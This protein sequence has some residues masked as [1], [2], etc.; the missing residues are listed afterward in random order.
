MHIGGQHV[1]EYAVCFGVLFQVPRLSTRI[2]DLLLLL[3]EDWFRTKVL[4]PGEKR[5]R[6]CKS[7]LHH[8][9]LSEA[10]KIIPAA[11]AA[12][13]LSLGWIKTIIN[14]L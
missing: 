8:I 5:S 3:E 2:G 1:I 14:S 6:F 4:P 13:Q 12:V 11:A 9:V 10:D 7:L